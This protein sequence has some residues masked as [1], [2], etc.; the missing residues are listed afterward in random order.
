VT[1]VRTTIEIKDK[2]R[3]ELLKRAAHQGEKGFSHIIE[4]ALETYY[5]REAS[6]IKVREKALQLKGS[7]S[8]KDA[9]FLRTQI[10][11]CRKTWR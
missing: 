8:R 7:L 6:L 4:E 10:K 9:D 5:E 1:S 11:K 3:A 2:L